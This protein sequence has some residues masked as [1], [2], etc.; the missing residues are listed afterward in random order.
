[1]F[2]TSARVLTFI[3]VAFALDAENGNYGNNN[4][5]RC[6]CEDNH[7]PGLAVKGL[8]LQV[9]VLEVQFRRGDDLKHVKFNKMDLMKS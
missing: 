6:G 3:F 4:D 9:S 7:E 1:L 5:Y 8:E 2:I